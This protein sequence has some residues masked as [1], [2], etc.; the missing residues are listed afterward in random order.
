MNSSTDDCSLRVSS[1]V[2]LKFLKTRVKLVSVLLYPYPSRYGGWFDVH[3]PY[4][5]GY[6]GW[7]YPRYGGSCYPGGTGY[8][9][10]FGSP[11]YGAPLFQHLQP[12]PHLC[13]RNFDSHSLTGHYHYHQWTHGPFCPTYYPTSDR[14]PYGVYFPY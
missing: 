2:T 5:L 1:L 4:A 11:G 7:D 10:G 9:V 8:P 3:E 13:Y 12:Y 6:P 14:F